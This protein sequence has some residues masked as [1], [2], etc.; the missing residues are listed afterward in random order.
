M[1]PSSTSSITATP[2]IGLVIEAMRKIVQVVAARDERDQAGQVIAF[3]VTAQRRVQCP[4]AVVG[5]SSHAGQS[6]RHPLSRWG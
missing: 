2:A 6:H 5:Q 1:R 3:H 4:D